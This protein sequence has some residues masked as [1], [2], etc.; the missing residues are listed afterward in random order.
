MSSLVLQAA[1]KTP[2][3]T[4]GQ[5]SLT[6][7]LGLRRTFPWIFVLADVSQPIIGAD[8]LRHFGLMVDL[9]AHQL[10]DS[11]TSLSVMGHA[12]NATSLSLAMPHPDS[13]SVY[14]TILSEFPDISQPIFKDCPVKHDVTHRIVT[15][16]PPVFARPRR[17]APDKLS[18]A[19]DEFS[20]LLDL[21][22]VEASDS[23]WSSPLHMVPKKT[24]DWRPCGD[25]RA[26]N[27]VTV[28]DRY[29]IPHLHDFAIQLNG[30]RVFSKID[31]VRAYHQIPVHPDDIHK[32]A[33]TTPFGLFH[34]AR[35]PFGLRNA[36]Q[37]F[38]RFIDKVIRDLPFVYAYI[39]DLLVASEDEQQ[40][41][42]HLRQLFA[43]LSEYGVVINPAK[44][45]F[46][47]NTLD[48]LGH[49]VSEEGIAPLEEKVTAIREFPQPTSLRQL[50]GFLGLV[51]FYRRFLPNCAALLAPLTDMLRK[52]PKRSRKPLSWSPECDTAF[53]NVKNALADATLLTHPSSELPTNLAVDA[54]DTA[55]G[56]VLQQ[57]SEG[58]WRP[59]AFFS[60]RLKPA[61]TRYS[62]FGRE[63]LAI[64]LAIRHFRH[65]L[66]GR[67]FCVFTDHKP[68]TFA[69]N[70]RPDRHS[71]REARH[72]DYVSQF[73]SDIR[74]IHGSDNT[75]ADALSRMELASIRATPPV[76][77]RGIVADQ[78]ND[79][80]LATLLNDTSSLK[81]EQVPFSDEEGNAFIWCDTT[82]GSPRPFIPSKHRRVVFDALHSLSHPGIKASQRLLTSRFVWPGMNKDVREW[83]R[84]CLHCQRAKVQRHVHA[85]LGTFANPDARFAHIHIDLVGPLPPSKGCVY[86]LTCVDRFTRWPEA[87]PI[88]DATA[89][90]VAAALV[91]HWVSRFGT[92][93]S[94]THDRGRQFQSALFTALTNL[95]GCRS[96]AT[97][98]YHPQANG[99]VERFH[100]QLKAS[101][102]AQPDPSRW[103]EL[104]PL[105]LLGIRASVKEDLGCAS[106]E[107][108]YGTPL[109][110]PGQ[111]LAPASQPSADTADYVQRLKQHMA[112]LSPTG[113]RPQPR[114]GFVPQAL[115]TCTHVF[116]RIDAVTKPL[117]PP[118]AGP[119]KVLRR[120]PKYFVISQNEKPATVSIDRLKPAFL[121]GALQAPPVPK[122]KTSA[123][124]KQPGS[125][126]KDSLL[127][128]PPCSPC[129][130]SQR[131]VERPPPGDPSP[132]VRITRSGRHVHWPKRFVQVVKYCPDTRAEF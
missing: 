72:L 105:V 40:H 15:D 70:S 75:V 58:V 67:D 10:R 71:P 13:D 52:Q 12:S 115:E 17:L 132:P 109:R 127:R 126:K 43:R 51:N 28:P 18:V 79:E 39:D 5:R 104:L 94:I 122:A 35:M 64:Y 117:Q 57:L 30:K 93:S 61:E 95:L 113:T 92:P 50:R 129:S 24:G 120:T 20:H 1:N 60:R 89:E 55:V 83:A 56:G 118:Y 11:T 82:T 87:I 97:T 9:R 48:F 47:A 86:L 124:G 112:T 111:L 98:A 62:T 69:L 44:C 36:A 49:R 65:F 2:I 77:L 63:L 59:I 16:G 7:R 31:L 80:E 32:T 74:H 76:D 8:F 27:R 25:Y 54:S 4:F 99:M 108:V 85:P 21:G 125:L 6:L 130:P 88:A 90:T 107:L 3:R 29:P 116:L 101:L 121:D 78:Q 131:P 103:R 37:T 102:K 84:T 45:Q 42:S 53:N 34:F 96:I 22:I 33:I 14:D 114:A 119:F 128:P 110:L 23:S 106:S 68:L 41:E 123:K 38:Q 66:E 26:L 81:L 19:K 46:G 91:E 73:T 100:R